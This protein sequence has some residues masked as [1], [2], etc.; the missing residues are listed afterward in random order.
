MGY[1]IKK[2][3]QPKSRKNP[4]PQPKNRKSFSPNKDKPEATHPLPTYANQKSGSKRRS[5]GARGDIQSFPT[6]A[7]PSHK[8]IKFIK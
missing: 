7:Y 1:T 3:A 6:A 8:F 4:V 2:C 5:D